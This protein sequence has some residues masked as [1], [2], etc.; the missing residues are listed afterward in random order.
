MAVLVKSLNGLTYSSIK[1]RDGLAAASIARI[2]GLDVTSASFIPTDIAGCVYWGQAESLGL[3]N[4]DPATTFTDLSGNGNDLVSTGTDPVFK[5]GILNGKAALRFSGVNVMRKSFFLAQ[6]VTVFIVS[7][8][9]VLATP[10]TPFDGASNLTANLYCAD[11]E[12]NLYSGGFGSANAT[13]VTW[14]NPNVIGAIFNSSSSQI[15]L[16]GS[17][18]ATSLSGSSDLDGIN[19]G[20]WGNGFQNP[21]TGD[22]LEVIVYNSALSTSELRPWTYLQ[23]E[24]GL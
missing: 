24:Y 7:A 17:Y 22:I 15:F 10:A 1:T 21:W 4:N 16:N 18:T 14:A 3:A 19:L 8:N 13:G 5:T 9:A 2:D 23:T 20:S 6:P 12:I 11:G